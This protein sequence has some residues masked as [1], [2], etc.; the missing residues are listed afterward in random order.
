M[1]KRPRIIVVAVMLVIAASVASAGWPDHLADYMT[2]QVQDMI[3]AGVVTNLPDDLVDSQHIAAGA[4]D[5]EHM[6]ASSVSNSQLAAD[7]VTGAKIADDAM[8]SEHYTAG[9]IDAE[10]YA[11]D[12]VFSG[13]GADIR[14]EVGTATNTE[15][16]TF[17]PVFTAVPTVLFTQS[18]ATSNAYPTSV[19]SNGFTAV[20]PGLLTNSWR[21]IGS[22]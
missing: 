12:M 15:V 4:V 16:V 6:S 13:T 1:M 22:N 11:D 14:I 3:D 9:S 18:H 8:D 20:V 5:L 2:N 19:A 17:S 21:A 10:H 7:C